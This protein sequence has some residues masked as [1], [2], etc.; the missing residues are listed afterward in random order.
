MA[1]HRHLTCLEFTSI[2]AKTVWLLWWC[3]VHR[4]V[5]E[6]VL[7]LQAEQPQQRALLRPLLLLHHAPKQGLLHHRT[8]LISL[9]SFNTWFFTYICLLS[10]LLTLNL[11]VVINTMCG[12]GMQELEY[13]KA[14]EFIH[15]NGCID[16]LVDWIHSNLFLLGGIALGLAIPQVGYEN[17]ALQNVSPCSVSPS[18][19][20][21]WHAQLLSHLFCLLQL[22]GIL[23]SQIL[24]NQIKDQI[25][26]QNY[27]LKHRSDPWRWPGPDHTRFSW[28]A[29]ETWCHR[30][31]SLPALC[32]T[33]TNI[34][35]L[36]LDWGFFF[37]ALDLETQ[38]E[39]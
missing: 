34:F 11:Q 15:T 38:R 23:L 3:H 22:V 35:H 5:P 2:F 6:H 32:I 26:L 25:E 24:I 17:E 13:T 18:G 20:E 8:L 1:S 9:V 7:R 30:Q 36:C 12:Q 28:T 21:T 14:V 37:V 4:L 31:A 29:P 33:H 10:C 27:N 16:K 39:C 19:A